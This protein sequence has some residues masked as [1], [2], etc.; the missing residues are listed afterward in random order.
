MSRSDNSVRPPRW[1]QMLLRFFLPSGT[2]ETES[3]DLLEAYRDSVYPSLG[4]GGRIFGL[5]VRLRAIFCG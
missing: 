5:S 4:R 3:G 2:A 1:A